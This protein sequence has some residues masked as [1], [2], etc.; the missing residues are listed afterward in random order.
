MS[1]PHCGREAIPGGWSPTRTAPSRSLALVFRR[2]P[3]ASWSGSATATR[4]MVVQPPTQCRFRLALPMGSGSDP[5][6]PTAR[7]PVEHRAELPKLDEPFCTRIAPTLPDKPHHGSARLPFRPSRAA[8][9]RRQHPAAGVNALVFTSRIVQRTSA[10]WGSIAAREGT[11]H[12]V[13]CREP[14]STGSSRS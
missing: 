12:P 7:F 3:P 11:A 4:P 2:L 10:I 13:C 6:D 1:G 14:K 8:A 5:Q 9:S